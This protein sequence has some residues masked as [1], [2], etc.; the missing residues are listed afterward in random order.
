MLLKYNP[1]VDHIMV[2]KLTKKDGVA[3]TRHNLMLLSGV[4]EVT[5][6]EW[7]C[8]KGNIEAELKRGEITICAQKVDGEVAKDLKD[9]PV[10][11]AMQY[12][13]ECKNPDTLRK[14][15]NEETREKIRTLINEKFEEFEIDKP[16]K[17]I[18]SSENVQTMTL[19]ELEADKTE[20]KTEK[21]KK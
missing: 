9:M 8:M 15:Y 10:K 11:V 4:N 12:V 14:W 21:S 5:E 1:K 18:E 20:K 2:V 16:T 7:E 13:N 6:N 3:L 17:E 19:E